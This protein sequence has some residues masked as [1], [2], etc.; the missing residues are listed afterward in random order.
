MRT[1]R[2]MTTMKAQSTLISQSSSL[3]ARS[4]SGTERMEP[5]RLIRA[6]S[7]ATTQTNLRLNCLCSVGPDRAS[8]SWVTSFLRPVKSKRRTREVR[9]VE[10]TVSCLLQ[11]TKAVGSGQITVLHTLKYNAESKVLQALHELSR[12]A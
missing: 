11:L 4:V 5:A 1:R 9:A 8:H 12:N 7:A 3:R 10:Q 6:N 2:L